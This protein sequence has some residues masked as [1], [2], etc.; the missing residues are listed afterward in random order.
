MESVVFMF[1]LIYGARIVINKKN[2][3]VLIE[4]LI[5]SEFINIFRIKRKKSGGTKN[6]IPWS[7][8]QIEYVLGKKTTSRLP[9]ENVP[10]S[11]LNG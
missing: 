9:Y 1:F 2:H 3:E 8:S 10:A 5:I 11:K 7:M 4:R 6:L